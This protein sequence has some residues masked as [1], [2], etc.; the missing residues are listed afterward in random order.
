MKKIN[1]ITRPALSWLGHAMNT[2]MIVIGYCL[3]KLVPKEGIHISRYFFMMLAVS[4]FAATVVGYHVFRSLERVHLHSV[5]LL[6]SFKTGGIQWRKPKRRRWRQLEDQTPN[7]HWIWM[8][9]ML[10]MGGFYRI[11]SGAGIDF[12]QSIVEHT[13]NAVVL[14]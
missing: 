11:D 13:F 8:P 3:I 14:F 4:A 5:G 10:E 1:L 2:S 6:Q 7:K 9:I 12:L